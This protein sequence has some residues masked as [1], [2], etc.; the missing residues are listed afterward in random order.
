VQMLVIALAGDVVG[1]DAVMRQIKDGLRVAMAAQSID[2]KRQHLA[3]RHV[4]IQHAYHDALDSMDQFKRAVIA[5]LQ[6][7]RGLAPAAIQDRVGG[8][9]AR[10]GC[11]IFRTHDAGQNIDRSAAVTPRQRTNFGEGF[12]YFDISALEPKIKYAHDRHQVR[13]FQARTL[14]PSTE[15]ACG[16]GLPPRRGRHVRAC[17]L[18]KKHRPEKC[19]TVF[20]TRQCSDK[21]RTAA[22]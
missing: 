19:I 3:D 13:S 18:M 1:I 11:G 7:L 17:R 9:D 12:W 21:A 8:R 10:G 2:V 5:V 22:R 16:R 4:I 20:R 6:R 15:A 14:S